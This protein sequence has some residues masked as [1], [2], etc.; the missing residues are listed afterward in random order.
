MAFFECLTCYG[1]VIAL[2]VEITLSVIILGVSTANI[3]K[4]IPSTPGGVGIYEGILSGVLA[5]FGVSMEVAL[6]VAI[7]DHCM[8]KMFNLILG[9]PAT[10]H[11]GFTLGEIRRVAENVKQTDVISYRKTD[12][13]AL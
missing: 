13:V 7:L 8:K 5:G 1:I 10:I 12:N 4:S 9:I 2:D 11:I 6:A 3:G